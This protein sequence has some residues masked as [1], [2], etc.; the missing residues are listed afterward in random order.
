VIGFITFAGRQG[1]HV[2]GEVFILPLFILLI[3]FGWSIGTEVNQ[4]Q[5]NYEKAKAYKKGYREALRR[6]CAASTLSDEC[7]GTLA[8]HGIKY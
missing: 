8:R 6:A 5:Q 4:Y 2:G 7:K 3:Y 1:W